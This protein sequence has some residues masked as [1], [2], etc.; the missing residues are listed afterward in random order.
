MKRILL[1]AVM[2]IAVTAVSAQGLG[3]R[4]GVN[5][6]NLAGDGVPDDTKMKTGFHLGLDYEI[7]VAPDF[8]FAPG[9]LFST[10]GAKS[11]WSES[12]EVGGIAYE[13]SSESTI[14]LNYL[15]VPLNLVYKPLL[16]EGNLIVA[17][18]PYL[19]YGIG[20]KVKWDDGDESGEEDVTFG[21]GDD[22]MFKALDMG[23]N[24]S[25]GY[26]FAS[27][28]SFQLNTQLGLINIDSEGDSDYPVK[29]TAFGLG[30]GYRF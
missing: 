19:G 28:F 9:L 3:L 30:L 25:F 7:P 5:F 13:F 12:G 14:V 15:E 4:G 8:Y 26:M 16:G 24:I 2:A 23:A 21:S 1:L 11:E 18:G 6:S 29:N 10:K 20:G 27:G 22:D 17:F